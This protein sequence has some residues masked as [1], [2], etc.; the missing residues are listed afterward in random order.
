VAVLAG[1]TVLAAVLFSP[2]VAVGFGAGAVLGAAAFVVSLRARVIADAAL[3]AVLDTQRAEV[4]VLLERAR[5]PARGKVPGLGNRVAR[6]L[7]IL[8]EQQK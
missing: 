1:L 6:A 8:R 4:A 2:A 5:I 7:A 3:D